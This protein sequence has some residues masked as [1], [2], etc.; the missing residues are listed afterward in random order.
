VTVTAR[1]LQMTV[2]T[3]NPMA[4][5]EM[6]FSLDLGVDTAKVVG[7]RSP[8]GHGSCFSVIQPEAHPARGGKA[9]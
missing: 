4:Y 3:R 6:S 2:A 9:P 1:N 5:Y 7:G 8:T